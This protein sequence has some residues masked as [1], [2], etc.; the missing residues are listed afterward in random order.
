METLGP[1]IKPLVAVA[2]ASGFVG[3]HIRR[4]LKE[5]FHFRALSRSPNIVER[6]PSGAST[7][8]R[9]CDLYS[10]PKLTEA[11]RGCEFGIYL[12]HSMAPSSRLMQGNFED[13]DLLLADNFIRAAEEAGLTHIIYLSGL[14]P[15]EGETISPH[16]RS[17]MEV[18]SVL[19]SR[20]IKVTVL[21]AGLIF[22]PGGSSFSMLV[23]LVRCFPV[24]LLPAWAKSKTHSIDIDNVCDAV[25][26]CLTTPEYAGRVFDLG[27]HTPMTY[28]QLI[29]KTGELLGHKLYT[30]DVPFNWFVL[31]KHWIAIFGKV[32]IDLIGPLQESL[33]HDLEARPNVILEALSGKMIS[34]DDSLRNAVDV[35]GYPKPNPRSQTQTVDTL[36][37]KKEKRVRSVQRMSLPTG[38]EAPRISREYGEWLS[39]RF[40]WFINA[41]NDEDGVVR[42]LALGHWVPLLELTPTPYTIKNR[43]RCAYYIS[44]GVLSLK[45]DPPGRFEFRLF[46]EAQCLV[47]SI[48]GFSPT[49]PWWFYSKTQAVVHLMVMNA[50]SKHLRRIVD[51]T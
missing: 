36:Q 23:N 11:L 19:K 12:V 37:I 2:G 33:Q 32:S 26:L 46:P 41:T 7:E 49:L 48:H 31:S 9:H 6:N 14:M 3:T 39:R 42:F 22:G 25:R 28:K 38:W 47:A 5:L 44:G 20:S 24:M 21:R 35:D 18:E 16:L 13:T 17:R 51:E 29:C 4:A 1:K 8:W 45:V 30:V 34:F 10:L 40:G 43:R 15:N 27:G 50:F